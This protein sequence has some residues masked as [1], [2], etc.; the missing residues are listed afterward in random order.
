MCMRRVNQVAGLVFLVG[1]LLVMLEARNLEYY[2]KLGPGS[3]F[4]PM[5]V[6]GALTLLSVIWLVQE[7]RRPSEPVAEDYV[8]KRGGMLRILAILVALAVIGFTVDTL[9]FQLVAFVFLLFLLL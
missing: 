4:F 2:T 1:S 3:G 9:G 6:G 5:W 8:P 7:S